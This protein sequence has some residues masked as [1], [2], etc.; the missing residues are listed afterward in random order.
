MRTFFFNIYLF[1][2]L[3]VIPSF[4]AESF[5]IHKVEV[6]AHKTNHYLSE[7]MFIGGDKEIKTVVL[8]NVRKSYSGGLERIVFDLQA[9]GI[10]YFQ[11]QATQKEQRLVLSIW[12][13]VTQKLDSTK[14][15]QTFQKSSHIKNINL[16]P[17][18]ERGLSI[19]ELQLKAHQK[20][21]HSKVEAFYLNNPPRII[22]DVI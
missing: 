20:P 10:P 3:L 13:D 5:K 16:L 7:G 18:V 8:N 14:V 9:S 19:I 6:S 1:I 2:F 22:I 4:A 12:A 15:N 21:K 17:G 11:V